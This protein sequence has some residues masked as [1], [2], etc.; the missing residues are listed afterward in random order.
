M[1][2]LKEIQQG[3]HWKRLCNI[4]KEYIHV[5]IQQN[6][7]STIFQVNIYDNYW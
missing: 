2:D 7:S 3:F 6:N 1:E 4:A 5:E